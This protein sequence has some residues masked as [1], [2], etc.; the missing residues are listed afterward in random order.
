MS[1]QPVKNFSASVQTEVDAAFLYEKIAGAEK[2]PGIAGIFR[3]LAE[4]EHG[5]AAK[6]LERLQ[7]EGTPFVLPQPSWRA[8]V[9]NQIGRAHV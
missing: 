3:S 5:H 4:I 7:L 8:R 6:M 2:D 9:P 1:T